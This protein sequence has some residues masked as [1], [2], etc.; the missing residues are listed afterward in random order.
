MTMNAITLHQP[1]ASLVA[2]GH[3]TIETR[4][5][6]PRE[7]AIGQPLAIHAGLAAPPV[8]DLTIGQYS[9]CCVI[10]G[11]GWEDALP[12]GKVICVVDL[13][14]IQRIEWNTR[15]PSLDEVMFGDY[16]LGRWMWRLKNV[17]PVE[18][19]QPAR[20]RQGMWTWDWKL[21]E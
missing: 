15:P 4:S 5:W 7:G 16:T 14:H 20:G 19:P 6:R 11:I 2:S 1:W 18:P 8:Q 3:K 9:A 10:L 13:E 12:R 17:R 21:E